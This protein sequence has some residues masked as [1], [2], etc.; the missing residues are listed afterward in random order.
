MLRNI[1][2][3]FFF[4]QKEEGKGKKEKGKLLFEVIVALGRTY[5]IKQLK[6][7]LFP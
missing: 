7:F 2:L 5:K 3:K 6:M 4:Q 1:S